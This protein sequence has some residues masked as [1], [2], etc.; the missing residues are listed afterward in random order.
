MLTNNRQAL[1]STKNFLHT[2]WTSLRG[3]F[4]A[5]CDIH[6]VKYS[7]VGMFYYVTSL[8]ANFYVCTFHIK[9]DIII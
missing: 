7:A 6:F 4:K 3:V 5:F 1:M 2:M 9:I 8:L